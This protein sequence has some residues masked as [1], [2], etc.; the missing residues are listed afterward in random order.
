[1]RV[2]GTHAHSFVSSYA[3]LDDL[4]SQTLKDTDGNE[5]PFVAD[6]LNLRWKKYSDQTNAGELA[7]FIAYAQVCPR[8]PNWRGGG[9][10]GGGWGVVGVPDKRGGVR[11]R[12]PK[13]TGPLAKGC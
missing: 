1:M 4:S 3:S 6:C 11:R 5:R 10:G 7:A 13:E 9:I 8:L 2:S 12:S